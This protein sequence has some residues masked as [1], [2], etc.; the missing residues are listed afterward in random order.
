MVGLRATGAAVVEWLDGGRA[1]GHRRGGAARAAGVRRAA[2]R[3]DRARRTVLEG[4]PDWETLVASADLVVPSPGVASS[5]FSP[6]T[7]TEPD[8]TMP[9]NEITAASLTPPPMSTT[10]LPVVSSPATPRQ[11]PPPAVPVSDRCG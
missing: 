5:N 7:R 9:F 6:P 2:C 10:M 1:R 11:S 8:T 4:A 3:R